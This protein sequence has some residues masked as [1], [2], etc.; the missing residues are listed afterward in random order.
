MA[1]DIE[2]TSK[3]EEEAFEG[4]ID[5]DQPH[6]PRHRTISKFESRSGPLPDAAE[7]A[8]YKAIDEDLPRQILA[9]AKAEQTHRHNM[10]HA[11]LDLVRD[12]MKERSSVTRNG[13]W[14]GF[15]IAALV[16]VVSA[17]MALTG[18]EV[19]ATVLAGIDIIGLAAVF[20]GT[21][22]VQR[23]ARDEPSS[24]DAENSDPE[25]EDE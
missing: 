18:H 23:K 7:L 22:V 25:R 13:Q 1:G 17:V 6:Q 19:L 10:D 8:R 16:L 20:V 5:E 11:E 14:L 24:D 21:K 12:D 2:E 4:T 3:P 9:M 15:G